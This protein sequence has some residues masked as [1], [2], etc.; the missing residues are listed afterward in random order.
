MRQRCVVCRTLRPL[1]ELPVLVKDF[2]PLGS[3]ART[4]N[5]LYNRRAPLRL[6]GYVCFIVMA[7]EYVNVWQGWEQQA[8]DRKD[9]L[10]HRAG[11]QRV[12]RQKILVW[13]DPAEPFNAHADAGGDPRVG[14]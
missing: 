1:R 11:R 12:P 10:P 13:T 7:A 3:N 5:R 8:L 2:R 6:C 4:G 9:S 14:W